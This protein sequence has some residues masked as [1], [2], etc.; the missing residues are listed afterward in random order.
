MLWLV[1]HLFPTPRLLEAALPGLRLPGLSTLLARGEATRESPLGTE[2]ALAWA[3]GVHRQTD[4]PLAPI[5]RVGDGGIPDN[6][7]WLRA[8][9]AHFSVMRDRVV[10]TT[11]DFDDLTQ[12]EADQLADALAAHFGTDFAPQALHPRRWYLRF[13][14]PPRLLTTPPSLARGHALDRILPGGDDAVTWRARLNE[15]QMLLHA[16]PVNAAREARGAWPVNGLWLWGGGVLPEPGACGVELRATD[17][18]L[19]DALAS[20]CQHQNAPRP[21]NGDTADL[22]ASEVWLFDELAHPAC[23]G[24]AWGWRE[25]MLYLERDWW[26]PLAARLSR[27]GPQGLHLVD[28]VSGKGRTLVRASAWKVWRRPVSLESALG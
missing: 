3:C 22:R 9:P 4:W 5:S 12:D 14:V 11:A 13:E 26:A 16:H 25:A 21:A 1:P 17:T 18:A 19:A 10:Y 27:L 24:D 6:A 15:A 23:A 28:P 2:A 8:D 20:H 7:Y